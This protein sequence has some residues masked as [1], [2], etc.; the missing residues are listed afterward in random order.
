[1]RKVCALWLCLAIVMVGGGCAQDE[2]GGRSLTLWSQETEPERVAAT[3]RILADFT[4]RTGI[5]VKLVP[6][7]EDQF[8]QV[9]GGAVAAGRMPDVLGGIPLTTIQTLAANELVDTAAVQQVLTGLGPQTFEPSA[10][11]LTSYSGRPAAIPSDGWTGLLLYRKDLFEKENLEK[12]DS[13]ERIQAAAQRLTASGR[14]GIV[15]PTAPADVFTAQ[16]FEFLAQ[17]NGCQLADQAGRLTLR[18]PACEAAFG[19][20]GNLARNYSQRGNQDVDTVRAAYLSGQA[21]MIP[22]SSYILD[23]LAG[24]RDDALPTCPECKNDR[25]WL[26]RNTGMVTALRGPAGQEVT[27]GEISSWTITADASVEDAKTLVTYLMSDGYEAWMSLAP[28]GKIPARRGTAEQPD[29]FREAWPKLPAGV[30]RKERLGQIYPADL[31]DVLRSG[32][33]RYV[34]WGVSEGRGELA[35]AIL[36]DLPVPKAISSMAG[37]GLSP[38]RA[39]SQAQ[40][41]I[42]SIQK[43]IGR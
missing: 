21:A 27:T 25:L 18:S 11:R 14:A 10:L 4:K 5:R 20:Y 39:A 8:R 31:I 43:S 6:M 2:P 29:R 22:W 36:G 26:A 23:E 38:Q 16:I 3:E 19:F 35:A 1:M 33:D 17:A 7:Q 28:E 32:H 34:R 37:G 30:D 13:Y 15:V 9:I 40:R 41:E 12:P 42:E 24:L